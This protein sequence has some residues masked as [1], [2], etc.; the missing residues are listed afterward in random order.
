M[1]RDLCREAANSVNKQSERK[2]IAS[3]T[4]RAVVISLVSDDRRI[5]ATATQWDTDPWLLNTPCGVVDLR[6]GTLR[7]H[8]PDDYM[9]KITAVA[10]DAQCPTPLWDAYLAKVTNN[11]SEYQKFLLRAHGYSLTGVTVEHARFFLYGTGNNGKSTL[12]STVRGIMADYHRTAP[13]AVFTD[14]KF[15]RHPTELAMLQGARVVTAVETEEGRTWAEAKI[16]QLT[17][18]DEVSARFMRQDFFQ[19]VPQ[20]KLHIA[21]NN[22]PKLKSVDVAIRRRM[23]LLPF[24]VLIPK[25]E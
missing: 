19:Y 21:G 18:G 11:D 8:R 23:N 25:E 22:K 10:P 14:D 16:K 4:T 15:E 24:T 6:T 12:L 1:A 17:G 9:T 2:R 7:E 20:F 5:A 13:I 3:A